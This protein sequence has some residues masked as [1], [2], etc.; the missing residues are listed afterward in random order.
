MQKEWNGKAKELVKKLIDSGYFEVV[1]STLFSDMIAEIKCKF[2]I[3]VIN[4]FNI[5]TAVGLKVNAL[6]KKEKE[7]LNIKLKNVLFIEDM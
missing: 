5:G 1:N 7:L 2:P 6:F 4:A 3:S